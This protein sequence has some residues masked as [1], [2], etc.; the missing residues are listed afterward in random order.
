MTEALESVFKSTL[1][2]LSCALFLAIDF[3]LVSSCQKD[4]GLLTTVALLH[5][6]SWGKPR[7]LGWVFTNGF[8]IGFVRS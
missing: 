4:F 3:V 6:A 7:R 1:W 8:G 2:R 5:K